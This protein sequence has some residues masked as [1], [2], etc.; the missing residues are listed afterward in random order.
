MSKTKSVVMTTLLT[1]VIVVL[2]LVCVVPEF[3]VPFRVGGIWNKYNSVVSVT[4]YGSDLGGGYS[5]VYYPEG[6]VSAEDYAKQVNTFEGELDAA[7]REYLGIDADEAHTLDELKTLYENSAKGSKAVDDALYNV[8]EYVDEY[9]AYNSA[10]FPAIKDDKVT[11][12]A[13]YLKVNEVCAAI[14][15]QAGQYAIKDDFKADFENTVK[16][17]AKRFDKKN[18][19]SLD[20]SVK[21]GVTVQVSVPRTV[22]DPEALFTQMGYTGEFV[23]KSHDKVALKAGPQTAMTAYFKKVTSISSGDEGVVR[24]DLTEEGREQIR[25]ITETLRT[26]ETDATLYFYIGDN[27]IIGLGLGE[28]TEGIDEDALFISGSFTPESAENVAIVVESALKD[29]T[30]DLALSVSETTDYTVTAGSNAMNIVYIVFAAVMVAMFAF[31]IIRYKG[32][33]VTHAYAYLSYLICMLMFIAFLPG[34]ALSA[35]GVLAVAL[36]SVMM[37]LSNYYIFE[38]IRKEFNT[39]KTLSSAIKA[40]YKRSLSPM[41][42]MH[43]VLFVIGL[44]LF[45]ASIGE[46][47]TFAYIFLLGV[48]MSGIST[49]LLTRYYWYIMRGLVASSKQ[50]QFSGFKREVSEDDED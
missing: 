40:G 34:M 6:V 19:K 4:S 13:L 44:V 29:G 24:F 1:I 20:V 22:E 33:G 30:V 31:S 21:D 48:L 27:Q 9:V 49:L 10:N 39:G 11:N 23:L 18:L 32:L 26:D 28:Q 5:A 36:T 47:A 46:V 17:I 41:L 8:T 3:T 43:I 7:I 35:S 45:F 42:D 2:C 12:A 50:H 15:G 37:V 16:V 25:K 14:S 38:N